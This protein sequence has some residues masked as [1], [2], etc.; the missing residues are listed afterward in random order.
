MYICAYIVYM[1]IYLQERKLI[2]MIFLSLPLIL[3]APKAFHL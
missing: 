1:C 3:L 2:N